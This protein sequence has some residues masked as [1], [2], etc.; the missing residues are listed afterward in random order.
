MVLDNRGSTACCFNWCSVILLDCDICFA[1][2]HAVIPV[3]TLFAG[4]G[5][6]CMHGCGRPLIVQGWTGATDHAALGQGSLMH[7]PTRIKQYAWG[8]FYGFG[9]FCSSGCSPAQSCNFMYMQGW[10]W[11]W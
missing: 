9:L 6:L 10:R 8:L 2:H 1:G 3:S 4:F 11:A 7:L 5:C